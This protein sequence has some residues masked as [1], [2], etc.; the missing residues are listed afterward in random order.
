MVVKSSGSLVLCLFQEILNVG[1]V[2][3]QK[4][5]KSLLVNFWFF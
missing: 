3:Y 1:K 5:W 2:N 4:K